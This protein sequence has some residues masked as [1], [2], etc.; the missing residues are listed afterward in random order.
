MCPLRLIS[1]AWLLEMSIDRSLISSTP[2][3]L[4]FQTDQTKL[5]QWPYIT[6][7]PSNT[8]LTRIS[9]TKTCSEIAVATPPHGLVDINTKCANN[10]FLAMMVTFQ[11]SFQRMFMLNLLQSALKPQSAR[12]CRKDTKLR[13]RFVSCQPNAPN[14]QTKIIAAY[15][16]FTHII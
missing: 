1:L 7:L 8:W 9:L 12:E 15:V 3:R 5:P 4:L 10:I 11:A 16:S 14:I 13:Q 2:I 6:R